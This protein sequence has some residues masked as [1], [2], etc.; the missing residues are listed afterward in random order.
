VT[1]LKQCVKLAHAIPLL[2]DQLSID[3]PVRAAGQRREWTVA[4]VGIDSVD[5][6][7]LNA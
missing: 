6:L 7:E 5:A 2:G 4:A 3:E 1:R